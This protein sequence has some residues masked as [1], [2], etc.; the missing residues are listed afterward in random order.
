MRND[1]TRNV[2]PFAA[3]ARLGILLAMVAVFGSQSSAQTIA[4]TGATIET[5]SD[6]KIENGTLV[7]SGDK[8]VSVGADVEIP[9]SARV[10]SMKGMTIMPGLVDPYLVYRRSQAATRTVVFNGR[11]FTIPSR[12]GFSTGSFTWVGKYFFPNSF[13]F[14]PAMRSGITTGNLVSDGRGLSALSGIKEEIQ[15]DTLF[16]KEAVLFAQVTNQTSAMDIIR[17]PLASSSSKPSSSSSSSS[18]SRSTTSTTSSTDK[19]KEYW[20]AVREGKSPL[21]VN[22]N[23][24]AGVAH[25]LKAIKKLDKVKIVLVATGP[26]LFQSLDEIK[27]NKNLTVVLQPGIDRVPYKSE[28]MNVSRMLADREIPF[29]ISMSLSGSQLSLSQDDPMFPL[30]MLVRTGLDRQATLK[31]VTIKPAELLGI[32]KTHGSL[33]EGKKANFLV[34]DGDPLETGSQLKQVF[35]NGNLT[36]EN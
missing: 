31:S 8:I 14:K 36:Y 25:L 5:V 2:H 3:A 16:K 35:L 13:N 23:S 22:V 26:N 17:K 28:F 15:E 18:T 12:T 1:C 4:Y 19:T 21:F 7:V 34:F 9:S 30:A 29:A 20:T 33:E 10:V 24:A 27:E 6:K 11:T 32:E